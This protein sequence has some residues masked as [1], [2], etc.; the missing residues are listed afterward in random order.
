MGKIPS[1]FL[2]R[3]ESCPMVRLA[4]KISMREEWAGKREV[5]SVDN[6]EDSECK[7]ILWDFFYKQS[8]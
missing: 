6:V 3:V 2:I 1:E 7:D 8:P 5:R 4:D